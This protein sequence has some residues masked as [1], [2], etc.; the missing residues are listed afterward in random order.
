VAYLMSVRGAARA[1]TAAAIAVLAV[2]SV[3]MHAQGAL[4]PA[5]MMWNAYPVRIDFDP[6]RVWDWRRPQFLAGI[7]F[8]PAPIPPVNLDAIACSAP[9]AAPGTPIVASNARG[10]VVLRW[11]PAR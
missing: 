9:P 10:T 1:L 5:A 11:P 7:T 8:T 4:N 2:V 3:A 6:I